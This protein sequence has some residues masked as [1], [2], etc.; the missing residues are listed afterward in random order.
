MKNKIARKQ[1]FANKFHKQLFFM[2]FLSAFLPT[3]I[4]TVTLY[5][6]IFSITAQEIGFPESIYS[7]VYPAAKKVIQILLIVFPIVLLFI[8]YVSY[9]ITHKM[10]GPYDRIL[11]E[12]DACIA[13]QKKDHIKLRPNDKFVSL[14]DRIN[15]LIDKSNG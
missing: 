7:H 10:V 1:F 3:L 13:G 11:R 9:K 8:A 12:L 6:L 5:Y 14:V 15:I 2:G 4:T